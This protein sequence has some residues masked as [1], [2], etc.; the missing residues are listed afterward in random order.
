MRVFEQESSRT[1]RPVVW[2]YAMGAFGVYGGWA[3][4]VNQ[5]A[6]P[7]AAITAGVVQG[8]VSMV[9][10]VVL[11]LLI[12]ATAQRLP[13]VPG[14]AILAG[15][16]PQCGMLAIACGAHWVSGTPDIVSAVFPSMVIGMSFSIFYSLRHVA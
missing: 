15:V 11:S 16:I 6:G 3:A 12:A 5:F 8:S 1:S 2:V 14:R 9:S 7:H 10:T 13:A 4:A